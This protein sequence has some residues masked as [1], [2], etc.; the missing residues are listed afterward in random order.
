MLGY[1]VLGEKKSSCVRLI[2]GAKLV[3]VEEVN[4]CVELSKTYSRVSC[5]N[6]SAVFVWRKIIHL[7]SFS[8]KNSFKFNSEVGQSV[9]GQESVGQRRR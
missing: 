5:M 1:S 8:V 3:L 4:F 2:T 7:V 6:F 9:S